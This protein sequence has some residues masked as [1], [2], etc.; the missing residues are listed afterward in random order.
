M[1]IKYTEHAKINYSLLDFIVFY[2]M[3]LTLRQ[4]LR[5]VCFCL[6]RKNMRVNMNLL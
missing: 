2:E 3:W 5:L 6:M 4:M 1:L